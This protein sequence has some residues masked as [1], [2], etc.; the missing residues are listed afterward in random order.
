MSNRVF[1]AATTFRERGPEARLE[2]TTAY[3]PSLRLA[4]AS[5][6]RRAQLCQNSG[7]SSRGGA[8]VRYPFLAIVLFLAP[9][10]TSGHPD[11][12]AGA[13]VGLLHYLADPFHLLVTAAGVLVLASVWGTNPH[14]TELMQPMRRRLRPQHFAALALLLFSVQVALPH[15][16]TATQ[17]DHEICSGDLSG[18]GSP[19]ADYGS[20]CTHC[21]TQCRPRPGS[22]PVRLS[23]D[24]PP[25]QAPLHT[26][27]DSQNESPSVLLASDSPR[28]PPVSRPSS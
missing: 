6:A 25:M 15:S 10:V 3:A 5:R 2:T 19:D 23:A 21:R 24:P 22:P 20:G 8:P 16:H 11:H 12:S 9:S 1:T 7:S 27:R 4:R 18:Q 28:A 26:V 14:A 13:A 17:H